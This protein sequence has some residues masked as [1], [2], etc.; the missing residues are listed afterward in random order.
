MSRS[1]K[2]QAVPGAVLTVED[3]IRFAGL[4][5]KHN[6]PSAVLVKPM[7]MSADR[8]VGLEATEAQDG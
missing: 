1:V 2:I 3:V 8:L 7:M 6:M 4:L 5:R